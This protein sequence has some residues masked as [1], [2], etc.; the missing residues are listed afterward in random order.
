MY[1]HREDSQYRFSRIVPNRRS[2]VQGLSALPLLTDMAIGQGVA[3]PAPP[4]D[5][6]HCAG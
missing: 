5:V 6:T 1:R 2:E 4:W 3:E